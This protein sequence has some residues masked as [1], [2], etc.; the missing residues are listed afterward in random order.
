MFI[1]Q[2]FVKNNPTIS[3]DMMLNFRRIDIFS[4][5][6]KMEKASVIGSEKC[7]SEVFIYEDLL[8]PYIGLTLPYTIFEITAINQLYLLNPIYVVLCEIWTL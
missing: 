8:L 1:T 5:Q 3:Y 2:Q 6:L 4:K 7:V